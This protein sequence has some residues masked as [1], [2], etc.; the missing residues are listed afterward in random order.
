M[1]VRATAQVKNPWLIFS[2]DWFISAANDI[3]GNGRVTNELGMTLS[4]C[5]GTAESRINRVTTLV[6]QQHGLRG[7]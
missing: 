3:K 5:D 2:V 1:T 6:G 7:V 4:A